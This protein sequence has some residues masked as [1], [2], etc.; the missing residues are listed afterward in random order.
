MSLTIA[1]EEEEHE[2]ESI[3]EDEEEEAASETESV[4]PEQLNEDLF[5]AVK[6]NEYEKT[7]EIIRRG[8]DCSA[9]DESNWTPLL[10]AAYFGYENIVDCLLNAGAGEEYKSVSAEILNQS[11]NSDEDEAGGAT[12]SR[13]Q[14][15]SPMHWACYKGHLH[16]VWLLINGQLSTTDIDQ[17]GNDSL[18]LAAAASHKGVVVSLMYAGVDLFARNF[19]GNTAL[20]LAT[21]REVR[22]ILQKAMKQKCCAG[23]GR[24][25]GLHELRYQCHCNQLMYTEECSNPTQVPAYPESDIMM[26]VRFYTD[27]EYKVQDA[28]SALLGAMRMKDQTEIPQTVDPHSP[29]EAL[30]E[31]WDDSVGQV[32]P[33]KSEGEDE[34]ELRESDLEPLKKAIAAAEEVNASVKLISQ[35]K[36]AQKRLETW[37]VLKDELSRLNKQ[38]PLKSRSQT[39]SLRSAIYHA[40]VAGVAEKRILLAQNTLRTALAEIRLQGIISVCKRIEF[41]TH[42]F[43]G[44]IKNLEGCLDEIGDQKG[45]DL[46]SEGTNLLRR[47]KAEIDMSDFYDESKEYLTKMK[48]SLKSFPDQIQAL[49]KFEACEVTEEAQKEDIETPAEMYALLPEKEVLLNPH[50]SF[51]NDPAGDT[52]LAGKYMLPTEESPEDTKKGKGDKRASSAGKGTNR[53]GSAGKSSQNANEAAQEEKILTFP[54]DTEQLEHIRV[55][56]RLLWRAGLSFKVARNCGVNE[57]LVEER[58]NEIEIQDDVVEYAKSDHLEKLE[59]AE[60][61]IQKKSKK[62]KGKGKGKKK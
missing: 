30:G 14:I 37:L 3:G 4:Q 46:V 54:P 62:G 9:R 42:E 52:W 18:H 55:M 58:Q 10:W 47:L 43:D 56:K 23:T 33:E 29:D 25:F 7:A 24:E 38:R 40:Q 16:C 60:I 51:P 34:S 13:R 20:D 1:E 36:K 53:A 21:D 50:R 15:N 17:T 2:L 11:Q 27:S 19:N 12:A 45:S 6:S 32:V 31:T 49:P 39:D 28:E 61:A 26:P 59:A 48:E 35:G 8:G 5:D 22:Y 57:S 44:D 41:A